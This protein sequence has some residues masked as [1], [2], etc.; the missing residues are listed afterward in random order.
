VLA[1]LEKALDGLGR[2]VAWEA[3]MAWL[4]LQCAVVREDVTAAEEATGR[5]D[6]AV[7]SA[8]PPGR[9]PDGLHRA[10]AQAAAARCWSRA[11]RGEVDAD[12]VADASALLVAADLPWEAS[13]LAGQAAI[14]SVDPAV[15]RRLLERARE[16]TT[17]TPP[18][19]G[20]AAAV[21]LSERE[22]EVAEL[23]RAGRTHREIGA[24]LYLSPKTVEHHVARM[25]SKLGAATR[26][27]FLAALAQV[28]EGAAGAQ[29][30]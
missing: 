21:V 6:R 7:P 8:P 27:E 9:P 15:A 22:R 24:Q 23:V 28:M 29:S 5:L 18:D 1:I 30:T 2:P 12:E 19:R 10:R 4:R 14:R 3:A 13:R 25:R 26:A 11:L 20:S 17:G 16:L